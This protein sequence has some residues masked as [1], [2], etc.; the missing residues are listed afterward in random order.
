MMFFANHENRV[1]LNN[2]TEYPETHV[3]AVIW[4]LKLVQDKYPN[5]FHELVKKCR[6]PA[7][8]VREREVLINLNLM[9]NK[10]Q[11]QD[12]TKDI[13][14]SS[15]QGNDVLQLHSPIAENNF[16]TK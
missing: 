3:S 2:G 13:V 14:L 6:N 11:V 10:G 9:N 15:V 1:K 8:E 4:N 16:I 5:S 7:Y 12:V